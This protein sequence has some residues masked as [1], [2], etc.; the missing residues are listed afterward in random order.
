MLI[1]SR[2]ENEEFYVGDNVLIKV[3][4]INKGQ[5]KLGIVAPEDVKILRKEL[6]E[7]IANEEKH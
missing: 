1:I 5:V 6:K 2:K 3:T 7:K 4:G